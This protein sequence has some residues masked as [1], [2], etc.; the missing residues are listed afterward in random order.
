[1]RPRQLL[2]AVIFALAALFVVNAEAASTVPF[3][4]RDGLI[5][6]KVTMRGSGSPLNFLLDSGAGASVL[7]LG[8]ARRI[9]ARL[10]RSQDVQ[11]VG[12]RATAYRVEALDARFG[13]TALPTSLLALDLSG[14]SAGV[15]RR[16]DGL[17][18]ADFF[19]GRIV[20]I[21]YAANQVR[22]LEREESTGAG[23]LPLGRRNDALCV[24]A[25]VN[26]T[27]AGWLRVDTGCSSALE[28]V[29]SGA[30]AEKLRGTSIGVAT[31][32]PRHVSTDLEIGS[33]RVRAV[34]TGL[35]NLQIFPGESGLLGNGVLSKFT[36]TIDGIRNRLILASR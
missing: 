4:Y 1:M 35:R 6:I 3:E 5:W 23:S 9:G 19:R 31:G 30:Q 13:A 21:D 34:T 28:W 17:L 33:A 8:T 26:G 36:V 29:A 10:G 16:I 14:V 7:D 22:L 11:G 18:G 24:R 12:G 15:S 25:S 2:R 20:Q 27:D 32:V